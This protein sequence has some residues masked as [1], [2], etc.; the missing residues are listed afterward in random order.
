MAL[1]KR[2][3]AE[4]HGHTRVRLDLGDMGRRG[5]MLREAAVAE[6]ERIVREAHAERE[7]ILDG[8]AERGRA[9]GHAQG[10]EEGRAEGHTQGKTEAIEEY[11]EKLGVFD[12]SWSV[13][14]GEFVEQRESLLVESRRGVIEL[15]I[16][17]A[18]R[19]VHRAIEIDEAAVEI[20]LREVLSLVAA[21]ATLIVRVHPDDE[22]LVREVLPKLREQF[23]GGIHVRLQ[24]DSG[25]TRGSCKART[26]GGSSIDA[27][28]ETQLD[29]IV[30]DLLPD[31]EVEATGDDA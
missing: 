14:M 7:R 23:I 16:A 19:V 8:S 6:A 4:T 24:T 27:T 1:I 5:E 28:V 29:R 17:I 31:R 22:E 10:L 18:E 9:E 2:A 13:A 25:V 12:D 15:A 21:P 3:D 11:R 30:R 20:Q 26:L